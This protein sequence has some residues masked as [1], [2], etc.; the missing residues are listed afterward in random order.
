MS[1][2]EQKTFKDGGHLVLMLALLRQGRKAGKFGGDMRRG[3]N[4]PTLEH[5]QSLMLGNNISTVSNRTSNCLR[6]F[7]FPVV[8][9]S[10]SRNFTRDSIYTQRTCIKALVHPQRCLVSADQSV[11]SSRTC[12]SHLAYRERKEGRR[13]S[14]QPVE[15]YLE[16]WRV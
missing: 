9:L 4:L 2:E 11:T 7:S 15:L 14:Q 10:F 16:Q 3:R 1:R 8:N 5:S 13:P 6:L 12:Q